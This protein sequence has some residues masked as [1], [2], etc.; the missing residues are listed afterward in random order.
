MKLTLKQISLTGIVLIAPFISNAQANAQQVVVDR[1]D[2]QLINQNVQLTPV[3][4]PWYCEE[5]I[6]LDID[7]DDL[8]PPVCDPRVCDPPRE[9]QLREP[10]RQIDT[11]QIENI[12]GARQFK[13]IQRSSQ[14]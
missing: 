3:C 14:F 8:R 6:V 12:R 9:I 10:L 5:P 13:N 1:Q 4:T 7:I 2:I 11:R